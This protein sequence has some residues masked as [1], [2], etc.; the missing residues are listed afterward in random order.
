MVQTAEISREPTDRAVKM[1]RRILEGAS[2]AFRRDGLHRT[3]MREIAAELGMH[4]G[5][6]YYY[7]ENR[8]EL[9]AFCQEDTLAGLLE[10]AAEVRGTD[11]PADRK[12]ARLIVGHVVLL[13]DRTPGSLAHLEIEA[14][15][16][17]WRAAIQA[18]RD[19]YE[20]VFREL[21]E[22]GMAAGVFRAVDAGVSAMAI[23]GALNWTVKWYRPEGRKTADAIGHVFAHQLVG[24]LLTA[25]RSDDAVAAEPRRSANA[26]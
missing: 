15:E 10:L 26:G 4:A 1:K 7:F 22:E 21:I 18:R 5:N 19:E 12:L 13:N 25:G 24:G 23:L 17:P 16:D 2:R 14:L 11:L 3:G 8:Q 20:R 6:L 9:L